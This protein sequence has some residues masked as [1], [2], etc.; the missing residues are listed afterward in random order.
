MPPRAEEVHSD[1]CSVKMVMMHRP[2]H[3]P[4]RE[5]SGEYPFSWHLA[6]K[7]RLWELRLQV[8]FHRIPQGK[9]YFG[10]E[11]DKFVPLSAVARKAQKVIVSACKAVVGDCYHTGGDDPA[12]VQGE[13]EQPAFVMPLWA[14]DQFH[15]AE[16]GKE[17]ELTS[18]L[19][20]IGSCRAEGFGAYRAAVEAATGS[21]STDKVYTFCFWGVSRYLDIMNWKVIGFFPGAKLDFNE[22][23]GTPPVFLT[24][25]ELQGDSKEQRHLAS[26][27]TPYF[28][29]AVWSERS[30]LPD[31][32]AAANTATAESAT[33]DYW[34]QMYDQ[35]GT[36]EHPKPAVEVPD[37]GDLLGLD[38]GPA[39]AA[40]APPL[41]AATVPQQAPKQAENTD[42]LGLF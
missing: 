41:A 39:A 12:Q 31:G 38:D 25:Y 22:L 28:R 29:A 36:Y 37:L 32:K 8:K 24:V 20:G 11:L 10:V 9:L 2:T 17:P 23:C 1:A 18:D 13:R 30:P 15:V 7:K 16:P 21:L 6:A 3:E 35:G 19:T 33:S 5:A 14:F 26:R 34:A 27:K 4:K 40:Q 42:L